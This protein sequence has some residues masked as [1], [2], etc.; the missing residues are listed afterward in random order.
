MRLLALLAVLG[1]VLA[2]C[3]PAEEGGEGSTTEAGDGGATTTAAP[4]TTAPE[5]TTTTALEVT[6]EPVVTCLVT[7]LAGVDDRSFN[8]AAWQGVQ[9]AVRAGASVEDP[10]LLESDAQDDYQPNIDQ[11]IE[12][13]AEHIVTVGFELGDATATNAAANPDITWTIVD[14][15]YDPEIPNVRGLVY[16]TD[17]AAG[18]SQSGVIGTYG[19]LNIPTVSIFMDG[20]AKGVA[21][22][23]EVKG[24]DVQVLGWDVEAKDGTFTGT[25]D[26]A[27]PLV[28][29][30]CES[31]L[32]EGAD[33]MLPVGGAINLPCGTAIQD[34]GLEAALIGV[35]QDAYLAAP[36]EYQPL[37]LVTI[38]KGI[39]IQV[40][41]S[42][43]DHVNETWSPGSELGLLENSGVG[44]SE[45]HDW[46]DRVPEE[47]DAEVQQILADIASGALS[48]AD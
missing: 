42:I 29:S 36:P 26:P 2:A 1:L 3:A 34:R 30:T 35:D 27:D 17:L 28:R 45:Y 44:L 40:T 5:A 48:I 23:N 41:R 14:F 31:I 22:Y 15:A 24:A 46:A 43:V 32:D 47:L 25:F 7:D 37:W 38:E 6:G 9:D 19:G 18:V 16:A 20:L 39:T 8:A 12:Q 21:H 10:I 11:C 33:I 4:G 13:G